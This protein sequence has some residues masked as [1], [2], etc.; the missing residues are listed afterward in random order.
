MVKK[1][2]EILLIVERYNCETGFVIVSVIE[3][4]KT[5]EFVL[6]QKVLNFCAAVKADIDVDIYA[7]AYDDSEHTMEIDISCLAENIGI[8]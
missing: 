1:I 8:H 5:P 4:G 7:N 6:N 3:K 2:P